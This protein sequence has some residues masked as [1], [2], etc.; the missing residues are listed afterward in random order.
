MGAGGNFKEGEG[1]RRSAFMA[2]GLGLDL[3]YE[4][5]SQI[6]LQKLFVT[7]FEDV[8]LTTYFLSIGWKEPHSG[9]ADSVDSIH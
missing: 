3:N 9:K 7:I 4:L 2:P 8:F 5:F 6:L 1:C